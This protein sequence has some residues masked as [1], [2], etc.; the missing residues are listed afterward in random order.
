MTDKELIEWF[1]KNTESISADTYLHRETL[2]KIKLV[3]KSFKV[4]LNKQNIFTTTSTTK[5]INYFG[6]DCLIVKG[7]WKH[8]LKGETK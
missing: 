4:Y 2:T 7:Q 6:E 8:K 5:L 3:G 1:R